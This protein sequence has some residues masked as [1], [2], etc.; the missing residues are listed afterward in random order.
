MGLTAASVECFETKVI[1]LANHNR[2]RQFNKPITTRRNKCSQARCEK[3]AK[4]V[5]I[6]FGISSGW[7][8]NAKQ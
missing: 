2:H 1:T 3:N 6:G 7:G 8:D 5:T 4:T